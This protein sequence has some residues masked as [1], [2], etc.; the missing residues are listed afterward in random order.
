MSAIQGCC[1]RFWNNGNK[2]PSH[3]N[4]VEPLFNHDQK[5]AIASS[6]LFG[7][8]GSYVGEPIVVLAPVINTLIAV[9]NPGQAPGKALAVG[10]CCCL[11]AAVGVI[12]D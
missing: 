7:W 2:R 3:T 5:K 8:L 12:V 6:L 4:N 1:L 10:A 11:S 9:E